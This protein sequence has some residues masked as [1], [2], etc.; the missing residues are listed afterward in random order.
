MSSVAQD[1]AAAAAATGAG[2]EPARVLSDIV[3]PDT[4]APVST[5]TPSQPFVPPSAPAYAPSH[6]SPMNPENR[7]TSSKSKYAN[8]IERRNAISK[9]LKRRWA[10]GTMNHVHQKRLETIKRKKAGVLGAE[11]SPVAVGGART[12]AKSYSSYTT[13]SGGL[14]SHHLHHRKTSLDPAQLARLFSDNKNTAHDTLGFNAKHP[15]QTTHDPSSSTS[16]SEADMLE[17]MQQDW[18]AEAGADDQAEPDLDFVMEDMGDDDEDW[19]GSAPSEASGY[20]GQYTGDFEGEARAAG[21]GGFTAIEMATPGRP[22]KMWRGSSTYGALIPEGYE[23]SDAIPGCP[24]ICPVRTCR[25]VFR[26][27]NNLGAHFTPQHRGKMLHDNEDGTLSDRG[28]YRTKHGDSRERKPPIVVSRGPADPFESPMVPPS[29]PKAAEFTWLSQKELGAD[30]SALVRGSE[31]KS[32]DDSESLGDL[33]ALPQREGE[34]TNDDI[35]GDWKTLWTYLQ[36]FLVRHKGPDPPQKGWVRQLITLPRVRNLEWNAGRLALHPFLDSQPRDVS[37]MIIQ[38]TGELAPNPCTKCRD[39]KGPFNGCVMIAKT[40]H[41]GP[42]NSIFACANCFYHYGQTYCSHKG[43]GAERARQITRTWTQGGSR[44]SIDFSI[45]DASFQEPSALAGTNDGDDSDYQEGPPQATQSDFQI[46]PMGDGDSIEVAEPDTGRPYTMWPDESGQLAPMN[47][48]LIPAGYKLDTTHPDRPWICP[49]RTCRRAFLKRQDLG[50]HFERAHYAYLF[51]DNGDGT[52]SQ[53]GVY[54]RK[55]LGPGGKIIYKAPPLVVSR[56]PIDQSK[57]GPLL[58]AQPPDS[59]AQ[60]QATSVSNN[61]ETGENRESPVSELRSDPKGLWEY[62]QPLLDHTDAIPDSGF[63]KELLPMPRQRD[64]VINPYR[65]FEKFD[66][67]MPRDISAMIIQVTGE[68]VPK[69]CSRCR[70]GRGPFQGCVVIARKSNAEARSRYIS[71]ANCLYH[72]NQT[73]CSL[74]E[75]VPKRNQPPFPKHGWVGGRAAIEAASRTA[76]AEGSSTPSELPPSTARNNKRS[77]AYDGYYGREPKRYQRTP[78]GADVEDATMLDGSPFRDSSGRRPR[79]R[80]PR[81]AQL[82]QTGQSSSSSSS[83]LVTAGYHQP[84]VLEMET[85]EVAPGRIREDSV[86][87]GDNIAFSK[88]YLSTNKSIPVC[89][90]VS[91]RVDTIESGATLHMEPERNMTRICSLATGKARVKLEGEAEFTIGPHGM[92]KVKAGVSC[93]VQNWL[94]DN[95]ILHVT[96]LSGFV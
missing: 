88:A 91:F 74:K 89:E 66:E 49:V 93:T 56:N 27:I 10:S 80:P 44:Q 79:G 25:K 38:V 35:Q 21:E 90:D 58:L 11:S 71:C 62:I 92:F 28:M 68:K 30:D 19:E 2:P 84:A 48:A 65:T 55:K 54:K 23:L 69:G 37:A 1:A 40:A 75:W 5:N 15:N 57:E 61:T 76:V 73:Y 67:K 85:W 42:L 72:G 29:I 50:F 33:I 22:Y 6:S 7:S 14:D 39:G 83:S 82:T 86:A 46:S 70:E 36:D 64:L 47:G 41:P 34:A 20:R 9:A 12:T 13:N 16:A 52:L 87:N 26:L 45:D 3:A 94:Y 43:W 59:A 51:N 18:D 81:S 60:D 95:A 63:V 78:L 8:D 96:S 77:S 4:P 31:S 53:T 32:R 17:D 24:W